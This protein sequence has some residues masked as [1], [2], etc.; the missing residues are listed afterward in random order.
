MKSTLAFLTSSYKLYASSGPQEHSLVAGAG[1]KLSATT[2]PT[3]ATVSWSAVKVLD[4]SGS[5]KPVQSGVKYTV[6]ARPES[7]A[8]AV[9]QTAEAA[10]DV[11]YT[12]CGLDHARAIASSTV[13]SASPTASGPATSATLVGLS[14]G[15]SYSINL[16]AECDQD[17]MDRASAK[18]SGL[19]LSSSGGGSSSV[20]SGQSVAYSLSQ[21]ETPKTVV[22]PSAGGG[23]TNGAAAADG[24][25]SAEPAGAATGS[26]S[27][28]DLTA[29][30][31][32]LTGAIVFV[33]AACLCLTIMFRTKVQVLEEK[34]HEQEMIAISVPQG[35]RTADSLM[36]GEDMSLRLDADASSGPDA[37]GYSGL[38]ED[39]EAGNTDSQTMED[40][41]AGKKA[42]KKAGKSGRNKTANKKK[43]SSLEQSGDVDE[44]SAQA[45]S[46][47]TPATLPEAGGGDEEEGRL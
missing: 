22:P 31:F 7:G 16:K 41:T 42:V 14:P 23:G 8:A 11:L 38:L 2:N 28:E 6:F 32:I 4:S 40:S 13:I 18:Q 37:G 25:G 46:S 15:V 33:L 43:Y 21:V 12:A 10:G 36:D 26:D 47:W 39:G 19:L 3:N 30:P 29:L 35:M 45:A 5:S 1:G 27:K 20:E 24:T 17:C 34:L 44:A 9:G